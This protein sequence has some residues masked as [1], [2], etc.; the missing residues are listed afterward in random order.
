MQLTLVTVNMFRVLFVFRRVL[1]GCF[2]AKVE[3][4]DE[5]ILQRR[6]A[7]LVLDISAFK[8]RRVA[9]GQFVLIDTS[10]KKI[11]SDVVPNV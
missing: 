3:G 10:K 5:Q 6:C 2:R 9:T 4:T 8:L 7:W 11:R 1:G